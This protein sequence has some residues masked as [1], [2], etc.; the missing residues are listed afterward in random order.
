MFLSCI[1]GPRGTWWQLARTKA[2]CR[3]GMQPQGRNYPCW[4]G[5][6]R[7]LVRNPASWWAGMIPV[8]RVIPS[9][10]TLF[11]RGLALASP[12]P[13]PGFQGHWPGTPTSSHPGAGTA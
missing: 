12:H 13:L 5:T 1:F 11:S 8:V 7:V 4:K 3:S 2:S 9:M 10:H 6:R